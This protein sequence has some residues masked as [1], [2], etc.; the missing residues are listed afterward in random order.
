MLGRFAV[1]FRENPMDGRRWDD[2]R[3][4]FAVV[5]EA[6]APNSHRLVLKRLVLKNLKSRNRMMKRDSFWE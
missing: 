1:F 3:I 4:G 6:V 5:S 2:S